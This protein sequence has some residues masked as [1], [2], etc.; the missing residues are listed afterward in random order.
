MQSWPKLNSGCEP[1]IQEITQ[2]VIPAAGLVSPVHQ[3]EGEDLL[4]VN[5]HGED[6]ASTST[7]NKGKQTEI[8]PLNDGNDNPDFLADQDF[9]LDSHHLTWPN[10]FF[11]NIQ[12]VGNT[13]FEGHFFESG[14]GN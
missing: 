11:Y 9:P 7:S 10:D 14:L 12:L 8:N 3:N 5:G 1:T 2:S 6:T 4:G 13:N